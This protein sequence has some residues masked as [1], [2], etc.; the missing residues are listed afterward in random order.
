MRKIRRLALIVVAAGL[1]LCAAAARKED[2]KGGR[3][4]P[5]TGVMPQGIGLGDYVLKTG[6]LTIEKAEVDG[7]GITYNWDTKTFFVI[8]NGPAVVLELDV[9]L[10]TKRV[11]KL[12]GFDDTEAITWIGGTSYAIVEERRFTI[13]L[14]E[15]DDKTERVEYDKAVKAVAGKPAGNV[16]LEGVAYDPTARTFYM[17]KEKDP[18]AICKM[19]RQGVE[20]GGKAEAVWDIEARSLGMK[21]LSDLHYNIASGSLLILS[22]ESQCVVETTKDGRELG[23][24]SLAE[25]SAGL[26]KGIVQP[27]GVTIDDK[28]V[29]YVVSEPNLLYVFEKT[30]KAE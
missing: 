19:T 17:V 8:L 10:K 2:G 12:A 11:I 13:C 25:G 27:E 4:A 30:R 3:K 9:G 15:I 23:R 5:A 18:R 29:L 28:G 6:P 24:L 16:G 7:S 21:D 14:I 20:N 22:D 26:A 1:V